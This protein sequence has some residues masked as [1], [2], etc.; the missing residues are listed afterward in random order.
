MTPKPAGKVKVS[1]AIANALNAMIIWIGDEPHYRTHGD[2]PQ[3]MPVTIARTVKKA[4]ALV[5][6]FSK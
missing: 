6:E 4:R 2:I 3:Q 1:T 5:E